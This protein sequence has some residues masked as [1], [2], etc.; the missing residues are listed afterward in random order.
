MKRGAELDIVITKVHTLERGI[1]YYGKRKLTPRRTKT[2][3]L[4]PSRS[5]A[6]TCGSTRTTSRLVQ[7]ISKVGLGLLMGLRIVFQR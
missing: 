6:W 5:L 3:L 1:F 2:Q 7:I 4:A